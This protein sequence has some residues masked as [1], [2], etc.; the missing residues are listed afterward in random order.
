MYGY[1][2]KE[3]WR[4]KPRTAINIL[5]YAVAVAIMVTII[6]TIKPYIDSAVNTLKG[7]GTHFGAF[8][9]IPKEKQGFF[10]DGG[11]FAEGVYTFTLKTDFVQKVKNLP[12]V[13]DA[14][15]Y[16]LF[17]MYHGFSE[18]FLSIGGIDP[19]NIAT[20]TAV[21]AP[22]QVLEG[23]YL[24]KDDMNSVML[25][26]SFFRVA[27][28]HVGDSIFAFNRKFKIVGIVNSG[29]RAA[30]A[31]MYAPIGVV[32]EIVRE[33]AKQHPE[34]ACMGEKGVVGDLNVVL[35]EVVDARIMKQVLK[36]VQDIL[37]G[38]T[39]LTYRCYIPASN[40]IDTTNK[41]IWV[42]SIIVAIFAT[43]V[44]AKSQ[45]ASMVERTKDIGILKAV[46]WT[47]LDVML[48]IFIE[49]VTQAVAG[50][51]VGCIIAILVS[52]LHHGST[53]GISFLAIT[54][55]VV[56]VFITGI[57]AGIIPAWRAYKLRPA[58]ALRRL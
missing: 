39:L 36:S 8:L 10:K 53:E 15:P 33:Y 40:V 50:G 54:G 58:E 38:A 55:G 41:M 49:S 5:G 4:H 56:L 12:G 3:L 29:I 44:A 57:I 23:R 9:T 52:L 35:V 2:L 34:C 21:C 14:A 22:T 16:F 1:A 6:S 26:E 11:P 43:L 45:L 31:D 7:V 46:G 47:N 19:D 37:G 25:E 48:Q 13:Q 42:L 28:L 24:E 20:R 32:Q 30:K 51:I 18:T 27:N 17:R